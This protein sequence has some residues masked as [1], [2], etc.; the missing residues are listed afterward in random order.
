[1][2]SASQS[3]LDARWRAVEDHIRF[4]AAHDLEPLVKTFGADPE[5]HNK[6][7]NDVLRGADA[8]RAFYGDLFAGFPDFWLEIG[9]RHVADDAIVVQGSFGG[10]HKHVWMGIPATGKK[11][12]IPFCAVF[13]FTGD[14]RIHSE[15]VYYDRYTL[16]EQLGAIASSPQA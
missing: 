6:P 8:I 10:T 11:A 7:S 9:S 12:S 14:N 1:V 16:L 5:W 4:E 15:I 13:T 3:T 2:S